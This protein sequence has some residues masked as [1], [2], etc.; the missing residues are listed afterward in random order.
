MLYVLRVAKTPDFCHKTGI[1][2]LAI[3]YHA[4]LGGFS[5]KSLGVANQIFYMWSDRLSSFK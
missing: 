1:F 2:G 5:E 4:T 3:Q